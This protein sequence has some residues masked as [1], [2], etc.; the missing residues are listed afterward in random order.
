MLAQDIYA[1]ED[2]IQSTSNIS[3]AILLEV[4]FFSFRLFV[5]SRIATDEPESDSQDTTSAAGCFKKGDL[6]DKDTQL[7]LAMQS[8]SHPKAWNGRSY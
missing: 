5:P 4:S 6:Q 8:V 2:A 3:H 1:G 7:T